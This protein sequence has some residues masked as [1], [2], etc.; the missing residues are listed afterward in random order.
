[1][2]KTVKAL[3]YLHDLELILVTFVNTNSGMVFQILLIL[4]ALVELIQTTEHYLLCYSNFINHRFIPFNNLQRFDIYPIPVNSA[5]LCNILPYVNLNF[6][7][8]INT[9]ILNATIMFL[10]DSE[11]FAEPLF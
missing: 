8:E 9:E 6:S 10:I 7:K 11:R 3:F 5:F 1:M 4:F 2:Y